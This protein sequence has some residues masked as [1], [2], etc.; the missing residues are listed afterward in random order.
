NSSGTV[1]NQLGHFPFGESW[2][3]TTA[4]K[5]FFTTYERDSESGN[6]Y[7]M[8]R[9]HVNRL[10]RF[11]S[12][13]PVPGSLANPQSFNRYS[14]SVNDPGEMVDPS[15][16]HPYLQ[17]PVPDLDLLGGG[18]MGGM[19]IFDIIKLAFEPTGGGEMVRN[20]DSNC[21]NGDCAPFVQSPYI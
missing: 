19:D 21:P 13:D 6:D 17:Q 14:Y 18:V 8:M 11:S 15:G 4:D 7:A 20:P 1:V 2:Y 9:S 10:A 12:A 3:S 16:L 5:L